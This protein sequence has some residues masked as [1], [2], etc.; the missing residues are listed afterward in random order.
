MKVVFYPKKVTEADEIQDA[1]ASNGNSQETNDNTQNAENNTETT[2][3]DNQIVQLTNRKNAL[4][5]AYNSDIKVFN[6]QIVALQ[7]QK[8]NIDNAQPENNE[9]AAANRSKMIQINMQLIDLA[10]KKLQRKNQYNNDIK[11]VDQQLVLVNREIAEAGGDININIIGES[12]VVRK[13]FGKKLFEAVVNRTDEMY[14]AIKMAFDKIENL[15]Y[16]PDNTQCKT[17]AKNIVAYLNKIG[18]ESGENEKNFRTFLYGLLNASHISLGNA[19][20]D[21]FVNNLIDVMKENTL[22]NWVFPKTEE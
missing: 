1:N 10:N 9:Q 16:S 3:L 7:N 5:N 13:R 20:K 15:S 11:G 17:F 12:E 2:E 6:D 19:E 8:A 4:K 18:W 14:A 22:F 21:K